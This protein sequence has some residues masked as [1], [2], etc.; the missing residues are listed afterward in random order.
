MVSPPLYVPLLSAS[1]TTRK[2]LRSDDVAV[3]DVVSVSAVKSSVPD[4]VM[5]KPDSTALAVLTA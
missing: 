4:G 2:L 3:P 5:R 1:Y